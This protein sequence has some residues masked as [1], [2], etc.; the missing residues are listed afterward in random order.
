VF[1]PA[2]GA[3]V[4]AGEARHALTTILL[5]YDPASDELFAAGTVGE[6]LFAD[7]FKAYAAELRT[8]FGPGAARQEVTGQTIVMP[9]GE[10]TKRQY[11]C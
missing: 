7:Y 1:D 11:F 5:E 2:A 6:E 3:K 8:E 10:Y 4:L 9:F